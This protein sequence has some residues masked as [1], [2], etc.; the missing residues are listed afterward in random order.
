M[1]TKEQ[2]RRLLIPLMFEQV[3][4]QDFPWP[5]RLALTF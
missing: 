2:L 1:Y 4:T 5:L 3:K